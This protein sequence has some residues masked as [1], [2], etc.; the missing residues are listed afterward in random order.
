MKHCIHTPSQAM[1]F[2]LGNGESGDMTR[3]CCRCGKREQVRW[4]LEHR[5]VKGHG[6]HYS[7]AVQVYEDMSG[8]CEPRVLDPGA[9]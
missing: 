1:G 8:E 3:V 2:T 7:Q 5:T 4:H 6:P 9:A